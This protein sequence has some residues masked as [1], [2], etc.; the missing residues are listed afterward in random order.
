MRTEDA[1]EGRGKNTKYKKR[2]SGDQN[3]QT[4]K[5]FGSPVGSGALIHAVMNAGDNALSSIPVHSTGPNNA[6]PRQ[7]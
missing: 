1:G 3:S 4:A 7:Q 2:G 6:A 5:V